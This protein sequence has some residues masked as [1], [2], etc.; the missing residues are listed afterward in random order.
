[1]KVFNNTFS[2][3]VPRLKRRIPIQ[4]FGGLR[5]RWKRGILLP[6]QIKK[7]KIVLPNNHSKYK[8]TRCNVEDLDSEGFSFW[9]LVMGEEF[10]GGK[11][12]KIKIK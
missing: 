11:I 12:L 5:R 7:K 10:F 6:A 4:D 9:K 1:M 3:L 2:L 8:Q